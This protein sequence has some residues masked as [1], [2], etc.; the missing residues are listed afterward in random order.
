MAFS[1]ERELIEY[2]EQK[3]WPV[4]YQK[5]RQESML[6]NA[7]TADAR[8][9]ENRSRNRYRDVSPY[10]HSRVML[11]CGDNDYIN[12]S[13]VEAPEANRS[14]ILAQGPLVHT[15]GDFW[16]MVWEQNSKAVIMLNKVIEKNTIKCHQYWPKGAASSSDELTFDDN[17]FRVVNM[18]EVDNNYYTVRTLKL[19]NTETEESR[20]ILHFHYTTWPDFGVPESPGEFLSFLR[21]VR[22]SGALSRDVGPPV[23]HC[24]A[25]IG[26]SGT[27]CIV[28]TCLVLIEK[29]RD[30][31]S[32]DVK[33]ILLDMRKYRMGLI[34]TPDQ[35]RFSY[36]A[37][38]EG[39]KRILQET[40][41]IQNVMDANNVEDKNKRT[42]SESSASEDSAL[43]S[44][45]STEEN[46]VAGQSDHSTK[47]AM[48][49][50]ESYSGDVELRRRTRQEQQRS[51]AEKVE[52]MRRRQQDSERKRP[53]RVRPLVVAVAAAGAALLI[54][55]GF[56][57]YKYYQ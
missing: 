2:D 46:N 45:N 52:Q 15:S 11:K 6:A 40:A 51:L 8:K 5:I 25:G 27:L 49:P 9:P 14:Y 13:L 54:A 34:Q 12:A 16:Q 39:G 17:P 19:V 57:L 10:D 22:E 28:D 43:A 35:L 21:A 47:P 20:D 41:H 3:L 32:I 33:E 24:S 23:I 55:G 44:E 30:P 26:R 7:S 1:I 4:V 31:E 37:I 18:S 56:L 38:I 42:D 53:S 29:S 48:N 36:L 50:S